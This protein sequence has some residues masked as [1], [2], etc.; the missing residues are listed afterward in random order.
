MILDICGGEC[1]EVVSTEIHQKNQKIIQLNIE[2]VKLLG[3]VDINLN[4]QIKLI[5]INIINNLFS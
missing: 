2:K 4:D 1:S 5:A 3:G